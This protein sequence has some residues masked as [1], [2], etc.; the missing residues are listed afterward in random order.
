MVAKDRHVAIYETKALKYG[1]WRIERG[2]AVDEIL[3]SDG[4]PER[5]TARRRSNK[6]LRWR[7]QKGRPHMGA[8]GST[9]RSN[10]SLV[11]DDGEE[12]GPFVLNLCPVQK[13]IAIPQPRSAHLTNY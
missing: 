5:N 9:V 6:C 2:V 1:Y 13:H 7:W 8:I 10:V 4:G 11:V 3:F 12:L